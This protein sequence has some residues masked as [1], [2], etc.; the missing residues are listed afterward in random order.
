[1]HLARQVIEADETYFSRLLD[2][3]PWRA[4][5]LKWV[6]SLLAEFDEDSFVGELLHGTA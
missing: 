1:M 5:H 4:T 3:S 6:S 2:V